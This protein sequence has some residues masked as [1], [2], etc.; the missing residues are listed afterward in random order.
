[1]LRRLIYSPGFWGRLFLSLS[2]ALAACESK[3]DALSSKP[4]MKVNERS[5]R[6]Q[7]FSSLL[8]RRLKDLDALSA[9]NSQT[10]KMVKE[11]ILRAFIIESLILD[12]ASSKKIEV[13]S[14]ELDKEVEN[15]RQVYPDDLSFRKALAEENVSFVEW[16]EQLRLRLLEKKVFAQLNQG[17]VAPTAEEVK[18]YYNQNLSQ[19]KTKERIYIRQIVV[20]ERA[21]AE[22]MKAESAKKGLESLARQYSIAPEAKSGGAVGWVAKDEVDFFEPLFA[23]KIGVTGPIFKSP[24]GYHVAVVEKKSPAST[25]A[26]E[27]VKGRI[28]NQ[29]RAQKEQ[30]LFTAWLDSQL[31][32]SRVWRDYKL[33][34]AVTVDTK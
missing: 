10:L 25:L 4:L 3:R 30:A 33:I 11:E 9:K 7:E 5:L 17:S 19:F 18:Q 8:A 26:F 20:E 32:S 28:E 15:I 14:A 1:M 6:V 12:Y 21:K 23:Y 27:E 22:L 2:L 31:R 34:D 24:Y 13:S 16:R 29:L